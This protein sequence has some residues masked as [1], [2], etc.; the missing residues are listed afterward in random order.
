M[1]VISV[2]EA[3]VGIVIVH[4]AFVG[5]P[6]EGRRHLTHMTDDFCTRSTAPSITIVSLALPAGA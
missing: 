4:S 6:A 1:P 2:V 5:V 3:S